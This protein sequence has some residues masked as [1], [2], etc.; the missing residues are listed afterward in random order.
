MKRLVRAS[1]LALVL[2]LCLGVLS[3]C[4]TPVEGLT[5]S[6]TSVTVPLAQSVT[7]TC[8]ITPADAT[9]NAVSWR[10]SD[11]AIATVDINHRMARSTHQK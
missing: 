11:T 3:G 8:T 10:S 1:S 4:D 2:I 9:N 6:S 7:V 5:V